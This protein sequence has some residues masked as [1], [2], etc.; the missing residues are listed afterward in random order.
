MKRN[1][2]VKQLAKL[3][4]V[5]AG[6]VD[7]VLH[8]RGN[9][10]EKSLRAVEKVLSEYGY[11][12]NIHAS[13]ISLRRSYRI[14]VV[15]P[16]PGKGDYWSSVKSG[17]EK[18]LGDYAD[19]Q[20]SLDWMFY[21]QFDLFSFREV[22]DRIDAKLYDAAIIGPTFETDTREFCG[23]FDEESIPYVFVDAMIGGTSP[24]ASFTAPQ[25]ACGGM[26]CRLLLTNR[27]KDSDIA[28]MNMKRKGGVSSSNVL[29]RRAGMDS[30]LKATG[31]SAEIIKEVE[32]S[33]TEPQGNVDA[34]ARFLEEN[35]NV[36]GFAV[37]NS[38]GHIMADILTKIG[39][40]GI[41][42]VSFDLTEENIDCLKAG[43]L[44]IIICQRPVRQGYSA[45]VALIDHL[46]YH[47]HEPGVVHHVSAD[48]IIREN[49]PYYSEI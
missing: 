38:R 6:T 3:A 46:L 14:L 15:I 30:Y 26:V 47:R 7:R 43:T 27:E 44:D 18:A 5:S 9:V 12:Y 45:I 10:S 36:K 17:I 31:R 23:R 25:E 24:Y 32:I 19:I 48:I 39:V 29:E 33:L 35:P 11:K 8:N 41:R 49:F 40:K 42:T 13:A 28:V 37:L 20:I 1:L 34:V 4:G 2:S 21:D 16:A 22:K